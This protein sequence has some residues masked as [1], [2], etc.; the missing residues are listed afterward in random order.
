MS[1]SLQIHSLYD[2][3]EILKDYNPSF[4]FHVTQNG[5]K[6]IIPSYGNWCLED[7]IKRFDNIQL[8]VDISNPYVDYKTCEQQIEDIHKLEK[9]SSRITDDIT[10]LRKEET[11]DGTTS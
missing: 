9:L 10:K 5:E 11:S 3:I 4:E 6:S 1:K 2:I 7:M 8:V